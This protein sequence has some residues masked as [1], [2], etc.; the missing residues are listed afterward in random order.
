MTLLAGGCTI[1]LFYFGLYFGHRGD[2]PFG[3]DIGDD[4]SIF[5]RSKPYAPYQIRHI[6]LAG[7]FL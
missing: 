2:R 3:T 1:C 4:D 6:G 5:I 7:D